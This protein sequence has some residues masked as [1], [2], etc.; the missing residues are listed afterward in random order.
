MSIQHADIADG[1]IH[2]PKGASTALVGTSYVSDGSGSG[3]WKPVQIAQAAC[4][5]GSTTGDTTGVTTAFKTINNTSLGGTLAWSLNTNQGM[6]PD[7]T[8][9]YIQVAESGIYSILATLSIEPASA[10]SI[11]ELTVGV[12]S[13]AGV[14]SKEAAV[15][16]IIR[17]SSTADTYQITLNC[18]PS[19]VANDKVYLMI[20]E[21]TG[22]DE[23]EIVSM[24]FNLVRVS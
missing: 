21:T 19:L 11:W 16:A 8:D 9:G 6:T 5:K 17:T 2:E 4:I 14:V 15:L 13:G 12:D 24:N 3:S 7:T 10:T 23:M 22:G 18:L 1:D 20:R